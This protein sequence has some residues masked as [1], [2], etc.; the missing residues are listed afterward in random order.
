MVTR[1]GI[2]ILPALSAEQ[3]LYVLLLRVEKEITVTIGA[4]GTWVLAPGYYCYIGSA[5][6]SGGIAARVHRHFRRTTNDDGKSRPKRLHWHIDYVL[7]KATIVSAVPF[8]QCPSGT[9]EPWN[10]GMRA[11]C[12]LAEHIHAAFKASIPIPGFGASDCRCSSHFFHLD[13]PLSPNYE[14]ESLQW[15]EKLHKLFD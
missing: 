2:E 6:G 9:R 13:A 1:R 3:G 12:A 14:T 10:S 7:E 11:E 4:L 8:P 15:L 5:M